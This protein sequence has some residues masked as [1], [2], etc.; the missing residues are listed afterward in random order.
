MLVIVLQ[1]I[2]VPVEGIALI[3][4]VDRILDMVRTAVNVTGDAAVSVAVAYTEDK[5]GA[6]HLE[7][8]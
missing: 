4:G 7:D 5:L 1:A 2:Q 8:D 6:L 3:L